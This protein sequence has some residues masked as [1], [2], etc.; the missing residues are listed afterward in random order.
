MPPTTRRNRTG[1][2]TTRILTEDCHVET[3]LRSFH[4][5]REMSTLGLSLSRDLA[6]QSRHRPRGAG[7]PGAGH[8]HHRLPPGRARCRERA[9]FVVDSLIAIGPFLLASALAAAYLSA[10][11]AESII[12][13]VFRGRTSIVIAIAALFGALSPFCSCGV[14]SLIAA[15]LAAGVPLPAVMAF[16]LASPLMDPEMIVITVGGLGLPFATAK[17]IAAIGLG[18][19]GGFATLALER[20]GG[21][22]SRCAIPLGSAVA[23]PALRR[24]IAGP[25][26]TKR[27]GAPSL[28]PSSDGP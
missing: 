10:A 14:I 25:S 20:L 2:G 5:G 24:T 17:T 8:R 3:I 23:A 1:G 4:D 28:L 11:G 21:C 26:G 7:H 27:R 18:L 15:L 16:W 9:R 12:G 19:F 13:H 6:R 22:A